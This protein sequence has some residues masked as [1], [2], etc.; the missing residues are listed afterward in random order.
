MK[1]PNWG[2]ALGTVCGIMAGSLL[3]KLL[4]VPKL[5]KWRKRIE[6]KQLDTDIRLDIIEYN[7]LHED[8]Y[9]RILLEE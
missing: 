5:E 8:G 1:A 7:H 9:L 3:T 2:I 6:R 4:F